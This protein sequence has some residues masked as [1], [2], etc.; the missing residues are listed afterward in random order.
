MSDKPIPC[1]DCICLVMCLGNIDPA[2]N[3]TSLMIQIQSIITN[4]CSLLGSYV[5]SNSDYPNLPNVLMDRAIEFFRK[6]NEL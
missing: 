1:K 5:Y 2:C 3:D 4:K 6:R